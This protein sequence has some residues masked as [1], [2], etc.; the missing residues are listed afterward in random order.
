MKNSTNTSLIALTI[1][2][3]VVML[4]GCSSIAPGTNANSDPAPTYTTLL[5]MLRHQPQLNISGGGENVQI[6]IRGSRSLLG[7]N[8]PLFVFDGTPIGVGYSSARSI[9]VNVV[10]SIRVLAGAQTAIYGNR[11]ANG[12]ILIAAKK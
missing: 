1:I 12:V 2:S 4:M 8:E 10:E 3:A 7:N 6:R 9:D 5:D 11:G